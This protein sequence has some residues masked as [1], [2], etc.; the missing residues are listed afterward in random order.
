M[1]DQDI[2]YAYKFARET[3]AEEHPHIDK[4]YMA[5]ATY[6][7]AHAMGY[8]SDIGGPERFGGLL[9]VIDMSWPGQGWRVEPE[10]SE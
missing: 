6:K 5:P 7:K 4:I 3:V 8:V 2:R 1:T 10:Y 9:V